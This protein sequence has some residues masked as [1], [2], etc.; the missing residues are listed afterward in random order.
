MKTKAF[1]PISQE[2]AKPLLLEIGH[3]LILQTHRICFCMDKN[4]SSDKSQGSK[5]NSYKTI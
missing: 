5:Y 4:Q 2:I 3:F 1:G